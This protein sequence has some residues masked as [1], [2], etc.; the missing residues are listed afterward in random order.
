MPAKRINLLGLKQ[1]RLTVLKDLGSIS[2]KYTYLCGCLCG[3][4]VQ[5]TTAELRHTKWPRQTCGNCADQ[6][7]YPTEYQIWEGMRDRC[8]NPNRRSWKNYGGRGIKMSPDWRADFLNFFV[9]MGFRPTQF[10][11][12]DRIDND[13]D[14]S[15]E[16]CRWATI[17]IQNSNKSQANQYFSERNG[18]VE[19]IGTN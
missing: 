15:K 19:T 7:K 11:S 17:E 1:G 14:Y 3:K 12:I 2:G 6:F 10:H 13:G 18:N 8:Y 5:Y 16:N 9:D 4:I